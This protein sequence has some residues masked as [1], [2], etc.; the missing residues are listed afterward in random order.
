M[1]K[2]KQ[3]IFCKVCSKQIALSAFSRHI[4]GYKE[5][6]AEIFEEL[7]NYA[8][9]LKNVSRTCNKC[10]GEF[11][12]SEL[13]FS[14]LLCDFYGLDSKIQKFCSKECS[15]T[16]WNKNLSKENTP[17]ILRMSKNRTGQNNPIF[18]IINDVQRKA[19]WHENIKLA[20]EK[21]R[22]EGKTK[23]G[24]S[25]EEI[26][27]TEGAIEKKKKLS[28]S[29]KK[30]K[31]HG[32]TGKK[33]SDETKKIIAEKIIKFQSQ[34][35]LKVSL[36]QKILYENLVREMPELD[37][38]LEHQIKYYCADIAVVS[39]KIAIEVDGDFYH[40]NPEKG[41]D[42]KYNIQI[43]NKENDLRKNKFYEENNWTVIRIWAS[44]IN[45][46]LVNTVARVKREICLI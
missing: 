19:E 1:P 36:P 35:K 9:N 34:N 4:R 10:N 2:S 43:K 8:T 32:H 27:G 20:H 44:D 29:A 24:L 26:M 25:L 31:I 17:S 13:K 14:E 5:S 11:F 37:F 23:L 15:N 3:S 38:Q 12:L 21:M 33:H 39:K 28:E 46:D 16:A 40:S 45:D 42:G 6:H 22:A 7:E 41:F 30:R 18:K